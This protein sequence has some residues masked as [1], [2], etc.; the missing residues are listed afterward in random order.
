MI[1]DALRGGVC[2]VKLGERTVEFPTNPGEVLTLNSE[3]KRTI[4]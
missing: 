2:K 3:R 1:I 4:P